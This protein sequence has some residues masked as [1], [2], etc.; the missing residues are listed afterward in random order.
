M[1]LGYDEPRPS[2]QEYFE[3]ERKLVDALRSFESE[4]LSLMSYGSFSRGEAVYGESDNDKILMFPHDFVIDKKFM[5]E[6]S[7]VFNSVLKCTTVPLQI[8][9][10]DFGTARD[11]RFNSFG[12]N[13]DNHLRE[14]AKIEFGPDYRNE[15]KY[16]DPK[17]SL[18][19]TI[20][21]NLRKN[22]IGLIFSEF[23]RN[24]AG[25]KYREKFHSSLKGITSNL[26]HLL[27][28][29]DG[30]VREN[31]FSTIESLSLQFP[32]IDISPL[33]ETKELFQNPLKLD[34]VY[35]DEREI[36][37]IWE[38]NSTFFEQIIKEYVRQ[39]PI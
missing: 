14:K 2:K 26:K 11:G 6:I 5:H 27:T 7:L 39:F 25:L 15:I 37:R 20:S 22:R 35:Q 8:S 24:N 3:V 32:L 29:I 9:P 13:W 34:R 10:L 36:R 21:H 1:V 18:I 31:R 30:K 33:K 23:Y 4:G 38:E 12:I 19:H 16:L 17:E 28:S